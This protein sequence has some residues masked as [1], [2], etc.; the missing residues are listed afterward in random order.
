MDERIRQ[1]GRERRRG[2]KTNIQTDGEIK[3]LIGWMYYLT[4]KN[5]NIKMLNNL[6][7]AT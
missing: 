7:V 3:R 4:K 6:I 1:I 2:S 5:N